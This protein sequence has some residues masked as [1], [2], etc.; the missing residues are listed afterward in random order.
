M[1]GQ[2]HVI[3]S[4]PL[5]QRFAEKAVLDVHIAC[6]V[7]LGQLVLNTVLVIVRVEHIAQHVAAHVVYR[8]G[9]AFFVI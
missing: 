5:G 6:P 8:H 9:G 3:R 2:P 1:L 4:D 7:V